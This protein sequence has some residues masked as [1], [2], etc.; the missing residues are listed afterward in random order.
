[1]VAVVSI[2]VWSMIGI[3]IW[4]FT[5]LL[6]D[7]FVGGIVGAFVAAFTGALVS[8]FLLPEP[9]LPR[10]NPPGVAEALWALPGTAL[11]LAASYVCGASREG[12]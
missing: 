8:G 5:V 1:M 4:H 2:L 7:R 9:G 11:A 12:D 10:A 6:P 3:A